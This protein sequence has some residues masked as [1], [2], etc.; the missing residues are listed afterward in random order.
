MSDSQMI[1]DF[2]QP[3]DLSAVLGDEELNEAQ[4]GRHI[5]TYAFLFR[6]LTDIDL[7][8]VGI[9]DERGT[10]NGISL[11]DAPTAI[12]KNLYR[13]YN[14]HPDVKIADI[15]NVMAGAALKD[16]YAAAKA[17]IKELVEA[18]KTVLILGGSHDLTLAQYG[19]YVQRKQIIE[20]SCVDAF[21]N[22]SNDTPVR[23]ENFL[24]EMLT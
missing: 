15:G 11:G 16:T 24:M 21:I 10:G 22:L 23:S 1:E 8:I 19:A 5:Q 17:V 9:T 13:L 2:L 18:K 7:V 3:V 12:R 14:W 4:L 6:D 20:A